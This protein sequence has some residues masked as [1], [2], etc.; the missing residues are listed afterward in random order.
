MKL[1]A[2]LHPNMHLALFVGSLFIE[3]SLGQH[4]NFIPS[5]QYVHEDHA[6]KALC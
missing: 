4:L 6:H 5:E 3:S 2:Q 1:A